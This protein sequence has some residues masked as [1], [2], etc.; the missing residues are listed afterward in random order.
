MSKWDI[1]D[2]F[3]R[4]N[5]QEGEEQNYCYFLPQKEGEPVKLMVPTSLQMGWI[6]LPTYFCAAYDN[7]WDVAKQYVETPI[8]SLSDHKFIDYAAQGEDCETLLKTST[9]TPYYI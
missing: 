3:W 5:C 6:K 4:I 8:G 7:G 2:G 1:T 9:R